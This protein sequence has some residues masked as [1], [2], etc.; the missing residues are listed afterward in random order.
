MGKELKELSFQQRKIENIE[1]NKIITAY[2]EGQEEK[3]SYMTK[4]NYF[5]SIVNQV[6]REGLYGI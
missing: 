6:V 3:Y 5:R 2:N 1:T 4:K